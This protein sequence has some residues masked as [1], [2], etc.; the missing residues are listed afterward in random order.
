MILLFSNHMYSKIFRVKWQTPQ[1]ET[2]QN[3]YKIYS[4]PPPGSGVIV[5]SILKLYN[6]LSFYPQWKTAMAMDAE[7]SLIES[8]KFAFAQ[9]SKLGDPDNSPY[10]SEIEKVF[11]NL[12]K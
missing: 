9:R 1:K 3:G 5:Q 11:Y 8:F 10:K 6:Q 4:S 12:V 2:L 7:L